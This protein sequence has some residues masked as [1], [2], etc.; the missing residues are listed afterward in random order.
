MQRPSPNDSEDDDDAHLDDA[1]GNDVG[2]MKRTLNAAVGMI[3]TVV[4]IVRSP[5]KSPNKRARIENSFIR[6]MK[7]LVKRTR[8]PFRILS[9]CLGSLDLVGRHLPKAL[10]CRRNL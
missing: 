5:F 3:E 10:Q 2:I 4:N 9:G 8:R 6:G 1:R 7:R